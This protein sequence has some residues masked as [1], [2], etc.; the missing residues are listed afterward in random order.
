MQCPTSAL[1]AFSS[2][3]AITSSLCPHTFALKTVSQQSAQDFGFVLTFAFALLKPPLPYASRDLGCM[4]RIRLVLGKS[5]GKNK[6]IVLSTLLRS[7]LQC[8]SVSSQ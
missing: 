6:A 1:A 8:K 7:C 2:P 4:G 3:P 5:K